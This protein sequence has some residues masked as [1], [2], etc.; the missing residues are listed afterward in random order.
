M[1]RYG[2]SR[3]CP[4]ILKSKL[5]LLLVALYTEGGFLRSYF[6]E[7]VSLATQCFRQRVT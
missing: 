7:R 6:S 5:L 1:V 3:L 2:N 4:K